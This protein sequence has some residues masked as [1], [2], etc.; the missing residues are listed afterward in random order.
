M[1]WYLV[2][3]RDNFTFSL[4]VIAYAQSCNGLVSYL[5]QVRFKSLINSIYLSLSLRN[6]FGTVIFHI[7]I[8]LKI[9][10]TFWNFITNLK[11][12]LWKQSFHIISCNSLHPR[13]GDKCHRTVWRFF[14]RPRQYGMF[15]NNWKLYKTRDSSVGIALGYGLEERGSRVRFPAGAGNFS[16]HHRVQTGSG[17]HPASYPTGTR[18]TFPGAWS[19][20]LTSISC[21]RQECVKL[22]LHSPIHLHGVVRS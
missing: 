14:N 11:Q 8:T 3:H 12:G 22:Y 13:D 6:Y 18:G 7:K 9:P 1:E 20:P 17:T 15:W 19:W 21:W 2:K 5:V 10:S 16:L 4:Y